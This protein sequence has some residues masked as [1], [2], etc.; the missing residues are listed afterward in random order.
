M[1]IMLTKN[2]IARKT[3]HLSSIFVIFSDTFL[4]H[5]LTIFALIFLILIYLFS[6]LLRNKFKTNSISRI[7]NYCSYNFEKKSFVYSPLIFALSIL[8]LL[9]FFPKSQAYVGIIVLTLGDGI[10]GLVGKLFGRNKIFYNKKKSFEGSFSM[11]I[12]SFFSLIFFTKN[13]QLSFII[14][15]VGTIVESFS[16]EAIDN[17]S[18]PFSVVLTTILISN[19]YLL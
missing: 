5:S 11:F 10:S 7:T 18:V 4:N 19:F 3:I 8:I 2:E 9:T 6:E 16:N 14:S 12:V 15:M 17:F 1:N 13:I